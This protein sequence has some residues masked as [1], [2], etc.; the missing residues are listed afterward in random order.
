MGRFL[1]GDYSVDKTNIKD[2]RRCK[3]ESNA[4]R[5]WRLYWLE[6]TIK[7]LKEETCI[8]RCIYKGKKLLKRKR[9]G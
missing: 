4:E 6:R 7:G 9:K 3:K 8:D 2:Y 5:F 1:F